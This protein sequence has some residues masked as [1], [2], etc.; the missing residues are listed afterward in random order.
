MKSSAYMEGP[1]SVV[2]LRIIPS[3][4]GLDACFLREPLSPF[5]VGEFLEV[6]VYV[7]Q[8]PASGDNS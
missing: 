4:R 7:L 5:V 3:N 1:C 6:V 2:Q 8:G